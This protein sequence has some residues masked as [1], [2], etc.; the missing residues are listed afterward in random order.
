MTYSYMAVHAAAARRKQWIRAFRDGA[1]LAL[2]TLSAWAW[3]AMI[4][5]WRAGK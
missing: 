5:D 1:V 4:C 2:L 3:W